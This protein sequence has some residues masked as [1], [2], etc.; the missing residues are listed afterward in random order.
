M[1]IRKG[2]ETD[3]KDVYDLVKELAI[4]EKA[5]D[6]VETSVDSMLED[7]FGKNPVFGF[8]VAATDGKIVG[9]SLYYYRYSTWKGKLLYLEDLVVL[10]KYRGRGIGRK[11]MD[12]T[13]QEA[14]LQHCNGIQWQVLDWNQPAIGFYEKYEPLFD[15][16]WINCRL[17]REQIE[18]YNSTS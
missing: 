6:E 1:I 5:L 12:A 10:E 15:P 3:L 7:G 14:K 4:Y 2:V 18:N 17:S 11:L 13:I 9:L 16:A 8:H